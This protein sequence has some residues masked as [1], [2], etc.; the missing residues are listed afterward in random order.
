MMKKFERVDTCNWHGVS[1]QV[2]LIRNK[3]RSKRLTMKI[4]LKQGRKGN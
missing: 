1:K 3:T 2:R 4:S